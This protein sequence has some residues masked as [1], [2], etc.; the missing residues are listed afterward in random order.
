MNSTRFQNFYWRFFRKRTES[1]LSNLYRS[2]ITSEEKDIHRT[3]LDMKRIS[4]VLEMLRM[5]EPKKFDPGYY[6][7]FRPMFSFS[8]RI[9]EL[10]VNQQVLLAYRSDNQ[11]KKELLKYFRSREKKL[12]RQF[13]KT[14][15]NFDEEGLRKTE[16]G[17]KKL[18]FGLD[19]KTLEKKTL[20]FVRKKAAR[21]ALLK[22]YPSNPEHIHSIRKQLKSMV[23]VLTLT[24]MVGKD[25][26][27][28]EL[29]EALSR[30]E[31][32][33]GKWHDKQVLCEYIE[34]FIRRKRKTGE[35]VKQDLLRLRLQVIKDN[36]K[37]LQA[38]FTEVDN[39]LAMLLST[40]KHHENSQGNI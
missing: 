16:K 21:I 28:G 20:K 36:E 5:L 18:C 23:T 33:I 11:G 14:V 3:R 25:K 22:L 37:H 39:V 29:L 35:V 6:E 7:V 38:L 34:N 40:E 26:R 24:S 4:A 10:Q 31:V 17:I 2:S 13:L 19:E 9:R 1:F 32:L 15:R 30:T 12:S 27:N 8:G